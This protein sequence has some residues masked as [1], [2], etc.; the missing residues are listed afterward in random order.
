MRVPAPPPRLT[1]QLT[2]AIVA[3]VAKIKPPTPKGEDCDAEPG[4]APAS[5]L[6]W[7]ACK[8]GVKKLTLRRWMRE[9]ASYRALGYSGPVA[10]QWIDFV[11][12]VDAM[13]AACSNYVS[14]SI[15]TIA[16]SGDKKALDALIAL[17]KRLDRHEL[18]LEAGDPDT[19]Q[20][21]SVAHIPQEIL[22]QLTDDELEALTLAQES[23]SAARNRVDLI[24]DAAHGRTLA[25][26]PTQ[27][28]PS[29]DCSADHRDDPGD[30]KNA[31]ND[32]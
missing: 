8:A 21:K 3:E 1:K 20:S 23:M 13:V 10:A 25:V 12:A 16:R 28:T 5:P 29:V 4:N 6:D 15:A 2:R 30:S 26:E 32:T 27:R 22:D 19:D 31:E 7:I 18:E 14:E 17:Q 24:L 11:D 9:G